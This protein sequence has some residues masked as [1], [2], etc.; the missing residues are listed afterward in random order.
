[1]ENWKKNVQLLE[2]GIPSQRTVKR[3]RRTSE[4]SDGEHEA[5]DNLGRSQP[6]YY[7]APVRQGPAQGER[8]EVGLFS[9]PQRV[10]LSY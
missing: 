5:F 1:M 4:C 2:A 8:V 7:A 6:A 3:D 10:R 9:Q